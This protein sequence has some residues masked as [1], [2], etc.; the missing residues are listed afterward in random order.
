MTLCPWPDA[1]TD[2][3]DWLA[4]EYEPT[5]ADVAEPDTE[6]AE[7]LDE[8]WAG[9]DTI[10]DHFTEHLTDHTNQGHQQ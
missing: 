5:P 10:T 7:W 2:Y 4:N 3:R 6:T 1:D 8:F 9:V